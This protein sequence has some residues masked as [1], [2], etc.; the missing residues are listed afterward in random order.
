M[1]RRTWVIPT[2]QNAHHNGGRGAWSRPRIGPNRF[3]NGQDRSLPTPTQRRSDLPTAQRPGRTLTLAYFLGPLGPWASNAGRE[4]R[5]WLL[6]GIAATLMGFVALWQGQDMTWRLQ[7]GSGYGVLWMTL[8]GISW[9][10]TCI[11]W[12]QGVAMAG[13]E[14]SGGMNRLPKSVG[15]P[16]F[17][18]FMGALFPGFGLALSG[19]PRRAAVAILGYC[20][21]GLGA[22]VL[23]NGRDLWT[24]NKISH[25]G[26]F[27]VPKLEI[28]YLAALGLAVIG[29][30]GWLV[31]FLDGIRLAQRKA[32]AASEHGDAFAFAL[33]TAMAVFALVFR[34]SAF[35][36]EFD[37]LAE[38]GEAK[39]FRITPYMFATLA[40]H[41][42][43]SR[44]DYAMRV[45]DIEEARGHK[46]AARSIRT[47]I[48]S[49]WAIYRS[50]VKPVTKK[51]PTSP[52]A[53]LGGPTAPVSPPVTATSAGVGQAAPTPVATATG[54][55]QTSATAPTA[56]VP[57]GPEPPPLSQGVAT[58][59]SPV[60]ITTA[61]PATKTSTTA[62]KKSSG[63]SSKV[64]TTKKTTKKSPTVHRSS[65]TTTTKTP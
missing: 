65:P 60:K 62:T 7:H 4:N 13:L 48:H 28:L 32:H 42:D 58:S 5:F 36:A 64:T 41:L 55:A 59:S 49:D 22:L 57:M 10:G 30:V 9:F 6:I 27:P 20:A 11:A 46:A 18:G 38:W 34:P 2:G 39:G 40:T 63:T 51:T 35:A 3:A 25:Y 16:W 50:F 45:A 47:D 29:M 24:W 53:T 31:Q 44:P 33:L 61:A 54:T 21:L 43:P 19:Y 12:S 23:L 17:I 8:F 1:P 56:A 15:N 52:V 14:V 26:G 37:H